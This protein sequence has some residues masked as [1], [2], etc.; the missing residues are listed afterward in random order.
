MSDRE[1][2]SLGYTSESYPHV[3][4]NENYNYYAKKL[5]I[6]SGYVFDYVI[7]SSDE[8]A[9]LLAHLITLK[10]DLNEC[11]IDIAYSSWFVSLS[12]AYQSAVRTLERSG[13]P[14]PYRATIIDPSFGS[15]YK[16]VFT[17]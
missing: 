10:E 12:T 16:I 13:I 4:A 1:K 2:A 14:F 17:K 7:E 15:V 5:F 3:K 8:L 9:I 11:S 6:Y